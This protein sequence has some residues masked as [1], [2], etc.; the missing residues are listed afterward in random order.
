MRCMSFSTARFRYAANGSVT[1]AIS[2]VDGVRAQVF[3]GR[4]GIYTFEYV[5]RRRAGVSRSFG[6]GRVHVRSRFRRR[7]F[8]RAVAGSG[9]SETSILLYFFFSYSGDWI[10]L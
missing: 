1:F 2:R 7:T 4:G 8:I 9:D 3:Y 6:R 10:W 5:R